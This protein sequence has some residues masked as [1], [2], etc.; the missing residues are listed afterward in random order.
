M[1]AFAILLGFDLAGLLLKRLGLPLPAHVTGLLL[2]A[3]ALFAG[4]ERFRFTCSGQP[5]RRLRYSEDPGP[6][7]SGPGLRSTSDAGLGWTLHLN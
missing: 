2:L 4:L 7:G 6:R 5:S 1:T 3:A